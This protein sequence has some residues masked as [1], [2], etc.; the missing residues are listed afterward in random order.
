MHGLMNVKMCTCS[1]K[2]IFGICLE[3]NVEDLGGGGKFVSV[4]TAVMPSGG[5]Y[6]PKRKAECS[7]QTGVIS[8]F[9]DGNAL[10]L[11]MH[12]R[13]V[14]QF[15]LFGTCSRITGLPEVRHTL[16]LTVIA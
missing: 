10:V 14:G 4:I 7:S 11:E 1:S 3:G 16:H 5:N 12:A 8:H 13:P 6:A 2:L 15:A 9:D